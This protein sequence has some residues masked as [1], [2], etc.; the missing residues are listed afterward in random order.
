MVRKATKKKL[1]LPPTKEKLQEV[2]LGT[3]VQPRPIFLSDDLS[4]EE[5]KQYVVLVGEY[6]DVFAWSYAK[7]SV[8]DLVVV[9]HSV[10]IHPGSKPIKQGK[11]RCHTEVMQKIK[12]EVQKLNDIGFIQ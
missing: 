8:L 10:S 12:A 9:M 7:M 4:N 1:S 5:L 2:N 6:L 11:K 3:E